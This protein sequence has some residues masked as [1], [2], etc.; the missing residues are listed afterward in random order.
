MDLLQA[1]GRGIAPYPY[2]FEPMVADGGTTVIPPDGTGSL[3]NPEDPLTGRL[4]RADF[5]AGQ[6]SRFY[7][8]RSFGMDAGVPRTD[9]QVPFTGAGSLSIAVNFIYR[10]QLAVGDTLFNYF[11]SCDADFRIYVEEFDPSLRFIRFI[12]P[13]TIDVIPHLGSGIF[14]T[15]TS[16]TASGNR[17]INGLVPTLPG[18]FYRIWTDVQIA[19]VVHGG[20]I[21]RYDVGI[22]FV[23]ASFHSR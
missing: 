9:S 15:G 8:T 20:G 21:V 23:L 19:M 4:L 2:R 14:D 1:W 18:N 22:P 11:L 3:E 16:R 12:V 6:L 13:N 5:R 10:F 7:S 17:V